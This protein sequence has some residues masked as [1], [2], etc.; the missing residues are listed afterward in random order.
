MPR[1]DGEPTVPETIARLRM[2]LDEALEGDRPSR[3]G[4]RDVADMLRLL[5]TTTDAGQ[6][7]YERQL[8]D[9][10]ITAAKERVL[11]IFGTSAW[12]EATPS[13]SHQVGRK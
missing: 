11:A 3:A 1:T 8:V 5:K 9:M 13:S 4:A 12:D 7:E 10:E 2:L 6:S